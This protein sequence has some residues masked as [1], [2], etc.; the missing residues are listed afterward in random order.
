MFLSRESAAARA[1]Y[2]KFSKDVY[3]SRARKQAGIFS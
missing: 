3:Q 2:G 1:F